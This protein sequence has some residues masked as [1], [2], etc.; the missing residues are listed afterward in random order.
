MSRTFADIFDADLSLAKMTQ[1][2][3]SKEIKVSQQS[4]SAWR[5]R[6]VLPRK[7]EAALAHF[8]HDKLGDK[9]ELYTLHKAGRLRALMDGGD[10]IKVDS[11]DDVVAFIRNRKRAETRRILSGKMQG[12]LAR[13]PRNPA[14]SMWEERKAFQAKYL[15][16][17]ETFLKNM[18][19]ESVALEQTINLPGGFSTRA[20]LVIHGRYVVELKGMFEHWDGLTPSA[21]MIP[22]YFKKAA[23]AGLAS[24]ENLDLFILVGT[25][26]YPDAAIKNLQENINLAAL[27]GLTVL[28]CKSWDDADSFIQHLIDHPNGLDQPGESE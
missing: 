13:S 8:M 14:I 27:C 20:D 18:A 22:S 19:S 28:A 11:V 23:L 5:R 4:I 9:S 26:G 6:N 25:A 12:R 24:E 1:E 17:F 21:Q 15:Q 7:R 10:E 2:R 3:L 16:N